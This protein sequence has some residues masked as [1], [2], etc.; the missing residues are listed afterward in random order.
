MLTFM[1]YIQRA[2]D[3]ESKWNRDNSYATLNLT[4]QSLLD[5]PT[6][7]GLRLHVSSLPTPNLATSYTIS[8]TG[9]VDGSLSYLY[10]SLPLHIPSRCPR[11]D[12]HDFVTG[13][14]HLKAPVAPDEEHYWETWHRGARIDTRDVLLYGRIFLPK[15]RLEAMYLRRTKPT[16]LIKINAVSDAT[17]NNGGTI[18]ALVQNDYGKYSTEFLYSTDSALLGVR[19][20]YNFGT[21]PRIPIP[22]PALTASIKSTPEGEPNAQAGL[23]SLGSEL[24]YG[25]LNKSFGLSTGLRFT[26][27]PSYT[28]FPYTMTLTLNPLM[29]NLSSSYSV[30]AG[31]NLAL[32]SRFDFNFY[33][34]ES[35]V[36]AGLELWRMRR[37]EDAETTPDQAEKGYN[38]TPGVTGRAR[39][40]NDVAGILKAR[41][42]QNWRIGLLWDGRFKE[43]LFTVGANIDLKRRDQIFR[44]IGLEVQYSS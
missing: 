33:S 44:G 11:L 16:Q 38:T 43:M 30:K 17:L 40:E 31:P 19:G 29:G 10:S 8:T 37:K 35:G 7:L 23:F 13:Y 22:T 9:L 14:R 4:A 36:M 6:P 25:V 26:T 18:L 39:S 5:F 32:S 12:L 15:N 41:I 20:L 1:D 24:Y 28:G 3:N 27:L 2:F 21:D 34:Y 42:D